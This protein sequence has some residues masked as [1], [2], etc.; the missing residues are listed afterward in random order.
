MLQTTVNKFQ[1][2]NRRLSSKLEGLRQTVD[3]HDD[4][5]AEKEKINSKLEE[6]IKE[7]DE[8]RSRKETEE[9]VDR[10]KFDRI[11]DENAKLSRLNDKLRTEN[12]ELQIELTRLRTEVKTMM[13]KLESSKVERQRIGQLEGER[14]ELL[15]TINKMRITLDSLATSNKKHEEQEQKMSIVNTENSKL[16]RKLALLEVRQLMISFLY[17][18]AYL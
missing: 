3:A 9:Q 1:H 5:R 15:E 18:H 11:N 8:L 13:T 4:L 10:E 12:N 17:T 7:N 6:L 16:T 2:E 14:D